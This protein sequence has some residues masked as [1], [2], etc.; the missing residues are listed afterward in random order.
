MC[1]PKYG[2]ARKSTGEED[3]NVIWKI[4]IT[5]LPPLQTAIN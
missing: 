1:T 3:L 2:Y 4:L 5:L